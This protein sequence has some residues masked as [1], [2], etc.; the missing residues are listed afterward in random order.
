MKMR[1]I[2]ATM[3][4]YITSQDNNCLPDSTSL[5]K[6]PMSIRLF[7]RHI[8]SKPISKADLNY[9]NDTIILYAFKKSIVTIPD[10]VSATAL[11]EQL[12]REKHQFALVFVPASESLLTQSSLSTKWH[13]STICG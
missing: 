10:T 11:S 6:M 12:D 4:I 5:S 2:A 8:L 1:R 9:E 13:K 7:F 3:L